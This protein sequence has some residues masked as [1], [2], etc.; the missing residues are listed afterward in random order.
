MTF[1]DTI[2]TIMRHSRILQVRETALTP[3][4]LTNWTKEPRCYLRVCQNRLRYSSSVLRGTLILQITGW[5]I[6]IQSQS[7]RIWWRTLVT[8]IFQARIKIQLHHRIPER[9]QQLSNLAR[10]INQWRGKSSTLDSSSRR[11]RSTKSKKTTFKWCVIKCKTA[12]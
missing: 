1:M 12:A 7:T 2:M 11:M 8:Q 9:E 3:W 10:S 4:L 6:F 5:V